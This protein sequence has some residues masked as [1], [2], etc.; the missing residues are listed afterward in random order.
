M[1]TKAKSTP[2]DIAEH[3][4]A[5]IYMK[6]TQKTFS[7]T[8]PFIVYFFIFLQHTTILTLVMFSSNVQCLSELT[9]PLSEEF[10]LARITFCFP[11]GIFAKIF[12]L[13]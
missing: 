3:Q 5:N 4:T 1:H 6:D 2:L 13:A 10:N 9:F 8:V 7:E 12:V 11:S